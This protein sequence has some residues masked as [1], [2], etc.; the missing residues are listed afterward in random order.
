MYRNNN[1]SI[2][3]KEQ[4]QTSL[5]ASVQL[6][7]FVL[8]HR[9]ENVGSVAKD[10]KCPTGRYQEKYPQLQSINHHRHIFPVFPNLK[11]NRHRQKYY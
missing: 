11:I 9:L 1:G 4:Q 7:N 2:A 5:F 8:V 3:V 6:D 10:T